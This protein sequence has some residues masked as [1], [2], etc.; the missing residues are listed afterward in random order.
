MAGGAAPSC[1]RASHGVPV[2]DIVL[3]H[4]GIVSSDPARTIEFYCH[5]LGATATPMAGHVAVVLGALRI[6][7]VARRAGDPDRYAH[8]HHL[9]LRAPRGER[10]A[11][12]ARIAE[13]GVGHEEVRGRIYT[14]D[15]DG[16]TLEL[17]FE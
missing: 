8:G 2:N 6:A 16:M 1:A 12:L 4:I 15:P 9:A 5:L 17:T 3:D 13:L 7:V 14:R 10:Q 11:L